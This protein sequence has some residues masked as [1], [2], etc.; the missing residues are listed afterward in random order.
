MKEACLRWSTGLTGVYLNEILRRR[1]LG[2]S[3]PFGLRE[4]SCGAE[5]DEYRQSRLVYSSCLALL[6]CGELNF[7]KLYRWK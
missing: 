4:D 7:W 3:R 2:V 6:G 5:E 1:G